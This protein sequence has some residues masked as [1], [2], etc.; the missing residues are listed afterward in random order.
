MIQKIDGFKK[1]HQYT[2]ILAGMVLILCVVPLL[3]ADLYTGHDFKFHLCRISCI[4]DN[5]EHGKWFSPIYRT[6]LEGYGYAAPLFYGDVFLHIPGFFVSLGMRPETALKVFIM[7]ITA[8][9]AFVTYFCAKGVFKDKTASL[10]TAAAYTFSSYFCVDAIIRT[11]L[12]ELQAFV[13]LPVIFLG[14]YSIVFEDGKKWFLLPLGLTGCLVSHVLTAAITVFFLAAF[15]VAGYKKF[16]ENK[17]RF[18]YIGISALVFFG[19]SAF[20]TFPLIEQFM[21]HDFAVTNGAAASAWGSLYERAMPSWALICDFTMKVRVGQWIPNGV[22]FSVVACAAGLYYAQL[23]KWKP[24]KRAWTLM[25]AG[26][27]CLLATTNLFPWKYVQGLFGSMQFPWRLLTFVTFFF[28]AAAGFV[29]TRSKSERFSAVFAV[30]I[31]GLSVFSYTFSG[32]DMYTSMYKR[33]AEGKNEPIEY[34]NTIGAGEYIPVYRNS[35]SGEW[36]AA[37]AIKGRALS[38]GDVVTSDSLNASDINYSRSFD[39][40]TVDFQNNSGEDT[41]LDFPLLMYKGYR[42]EIN[43]KKAEIGYGVN[44]LVRV[45]LGGTESGTITVRYEGTAIQTVSKIISAVSFAALA[46]YLVYLKK[47]VLKR[48]YKNSSPSVP[49]R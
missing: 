9:C 4:A 21:S 33:T 8:A 28:A 44:S 27:A 48:L 7:L 40:L 18:V 13:F 32:S 35:A 2:F 37:S 26:T 49:N 43:G 12:G 16:L 15:A 46:C 1:R 17:K 39:T 29:L 36:E 45:R 23:K 19:F 30:I 38:R 47:D 22:G 11:A 31:V 10:V 34:K 6:Y 3:R 20:F 14:F 24:G 42:A 41:Y 25:I 5:I